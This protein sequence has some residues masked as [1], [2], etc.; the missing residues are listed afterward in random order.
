M[1]EATM[2]KEMELCT[3]EVE[4]ASQHSPQPQKKKGGI[5][6]MPFIMGIHFVLFLIIT[7]KNMD[8]VWCFFFYG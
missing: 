4:M 8:L 6:T 1:K 3:S 7:K 2:E 5:V